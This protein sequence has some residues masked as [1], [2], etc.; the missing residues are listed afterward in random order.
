MEFKAGLDEEEGV[1]RVRIFILGAALALLLPAAPAGAADLSATATVL[2]GSRSLTTATM[3]PFGSVV[4]TLNAD[5]TL[6]VVVT[7]AAATA[8][9]NGWTVTAR[10]CGPNDVTTPTA[11]DCA[12]YPDQLVK[13]GDAAKVISG[14]N[15]SIRGGTLTPLVT[16]LPSNPTTPTGLTADTA[17]DQTRTL[18]SSG[19]QN[20]ASVYTGT[21]TYGATVRLTPPVGADTAVYNGYVVVT[22]VL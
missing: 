1:N 5:A 8:D 15:V 18:I 6:A 11:S 3:T 12:T 19:N 9:T 14:S 20:G 22:L 2:D 16:S 7:E 21:Y 4:R 13:T 17:L 10:L